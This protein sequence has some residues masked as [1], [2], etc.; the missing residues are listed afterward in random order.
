MRMHLRELLYSPEDELMLMKVG[1]RVED[2]LEA[3]PFDAE[4]V[5]PNSDTAKILGKAETFSHV[6]NL[7]ALGDSVLR[8]I[9]WTLLLSFLIYLNLS[10]D[11]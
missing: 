6:G 3:N 10:L 2:S 1:S 5:P 8:I 4:L 9:R 7:S 11:P